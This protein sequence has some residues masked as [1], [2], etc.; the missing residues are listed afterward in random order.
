LLTN[1]L[2]VEAGKKNFGPRHT[3]LDP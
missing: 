3:F 1:E 2:P